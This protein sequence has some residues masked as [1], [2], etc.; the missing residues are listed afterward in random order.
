MLNTSLLR[1]TD[2]DLTPTQR[3]LLELNAFLQS[4]NS[5]GI[6][7][8]KESLSNPVRLMLE[9]Q[10]LDT[11]QDSQILNDDEHDTIG[12]SDYRKKSKKKKKKQDQLDAEQLQRIEE[13][14]AREFSRAYEHVEEKLE[15]VQGNVNNQIARIE[16]ELRSEED[17]CDK[18]VRKLLAKKDRLSSLKDR[19]KI[20]KKALKKAGSAAAVL[21]I[22]RELF[23]DIEAYHERGEFPPTREVQNLFSLIDDVL[24]DLQIKQL[25]ENGFDFRFQRGDGDDDSCGD[26]CTPGPDD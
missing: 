11:G 23:A 12:I 13:E 6:D 24:A 22:E 26:D 14:I 7:S 21:Q 3:S 25:L 2:D 17:M 15:H 1:A 10:G 19:T 4:P 18:R 8:L 16:E 5:V 20:Y 9:L